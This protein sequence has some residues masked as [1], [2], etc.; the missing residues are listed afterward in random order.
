ME[1]QFLDKGAT[2]YAPLLVSRQYRSRQF[3]TATRGLATCEFPYEGRG[4]KK[5]VS[6]IPEAWKRIYKMEPF[7]EKPR[8]MPEY[9]RWRSMRINDDIPL[10]DPENNV[11]VEERL[12]VDPSEMEIVKHDFKK[13]YLM[14]ESRLSGLENEK[15][16]LKFGMQSQEREIERLRKGKGKAEEDL[17]NLRND[18]KKLRA[19]AKYAGLGKTS[20]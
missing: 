19:S 3:I 14:M 16:Q 17:N 8:V 12:R 4:Y 18:Y 10:P 15:N 11:P 7:D 2:G 5:N 20:A 13:K 6:K 9:R 1:N